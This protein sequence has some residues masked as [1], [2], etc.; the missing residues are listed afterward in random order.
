[1]NHNCVERGGK[2]MIYLCPSLMCANVLK[3]GEEIKELEAGGA[4]MLHCDIFD[5]IYLNNF[6]MGFHTLEQI[7]SVTSLALEIHLAVYNPEKHID[8]LAKI[9]VNS[10]AVHLGTTPHIGKLMENIKSKGMQA[11]LVLNIPD[12]PQELT[13]LINLAD[14]VVIMTVSLGFYGQKFKP[15][16]LSKIKSVK[17]IANNHKVN[18]IIQVDGN[19]NKDT[20]PSCLRA[21]ANSFVLGTS[22]IFKN[23]L[24]RMKGLQEIRKFINKVR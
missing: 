5:G 2:Y 16:V 15:E 19:I 3:L 17:E 12:L 22:S 21:G 6:G 1:M 18:P 23:G 20:I 8:T 11:G 10:I 14:I 7:R 24:N 13:Y 4:D 9:G